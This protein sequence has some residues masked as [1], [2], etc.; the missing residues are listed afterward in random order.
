MSKFQYGL[1]GVA[2][3]L[4]LGKKGGRLVYDKDVGIF[5][6]TATDGTTA[7]RIK[8]A[9]GV[10]IDDAV[11]LSQLD[12]E[13]LA[14]EG[15]I[16][17]V[18]LKVGD[19]SELDV[20]FVATD[21]VGAVN[22]VHTALG[23]VVEDL[24][25]MSK[26]DA[27][28][29]A[30]TGGTIDVPLINTGVIN[31][32]VVDAGVIIEGSKFEKGDLSTKDLTV[33]GDLVVRGNT[34]SL[35]VSEL[36]VEDNIIE[37]NSGDTGD[38][39]TLNTAGIEI[40]RGTKDNVFMI[41][42]E[43]ANTG[44]GAF[45]FKNATGDIVKIIADFDLGDQLIARKNGGFGA[46]ISGHAD[47]SLLTADGTEI[48]IGAEHQV[49][50]VTDTG[51]HEYK[52]A[53]ALRNDTGQVVVST[54]GAASVTGEYLDI[55]NTTDRVTLSAKNLD[56]IG[57]VNLYLQG[58]GD[59]DVI[60]SANA[61]NEGLIIGEDGT[62]LTISGGNSGDTNAGNM[63]IKGGDGTGVLTSGD[64]I[65]QGGSGG[66][67][68]GIVIIRDS[69]GNLV[70]TFTG[71]TVDAVDFVDF[72]NGVGDTEIKA[73]GTSTDINLVLTAKGDGYVVA[74]VGYDIT[75]APDEAFVTKGALADVANSVDPLIKRA[76]FTA[77][78]VTSMF[79]I[80]VLNNVADKV[81]YVSRVTINVGTEIVGATEMTVG[82]SVATLVSADES[83]TMVGTYVADL[84]FAVASAG[85]STF[86]LTFDSIPT[87]GQVTAI[88]EYKVVD[89]V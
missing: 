11:S 53:S 31:E 32:S 33:T 30:I 62:T 28:E 56:G 73:S 80:G 87:A 63:V 36:K 59:G 74:P 1:S 83:D 46:D 51:T 2:G 50:T 52:Y 77:D 75:N 65:L 23:L 88:V 44:A 47:T 78:G 22:E 41:W 9:D 48:V 45:V 57:D 39:I 60:V 17:I 70:A 81:Y 82:D 64:V 55:S 14:L 7:S 66:S 16:E 24:G 49:L 76:T 26:Q 6:L 18:D 13:V 34:V 21:L 5:K 89:V 40:N 37:I 35:E 29:V 4:Q 20:G 8:I 69:A 61:S 68:E 12:A 84:P 85:G 58:Q 79:T 72:V 38:G 25:T 42:D 19:T 15:A 27:D 3:D 67:E 86:S 43:T 10:D 54:S 71:G